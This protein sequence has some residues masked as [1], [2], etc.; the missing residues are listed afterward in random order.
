MVELLETRR[1]LDS[2]IW[3]ESAT[4]QTSHGA[5][6]TESTPGSQEMDSS[7]SWTLNL[8]GIPGHGHMSAVSFNVAVFE[9]QDGC[10]DSG[11][12]DGCGGSCGG[13]GGSAPDDS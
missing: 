8:S 13:G 10:G 11:C 5:A 6:A 9:H 3:S 4:P 2:T 7:T 1:M 12:G